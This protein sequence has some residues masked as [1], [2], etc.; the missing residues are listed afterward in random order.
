MDVKEIQDI[1]LR[2]LR[3]ERVTK[4]EEDRLF[5]YYEEHIFWG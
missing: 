4:E 3:K 5:K 2:Y 1:L